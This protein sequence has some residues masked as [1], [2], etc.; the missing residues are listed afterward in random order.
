MTTLKTCTDGELVLGFKLL[1]F[2]VRGQVRPNKIIFIAADAAI[3]LCV[4]Y[5]AKIVA[6]NPLAVYARAQ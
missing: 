3:P 6:L 4:V 5:R 1:L 2:G